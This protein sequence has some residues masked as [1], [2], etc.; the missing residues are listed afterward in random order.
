MKKKILMIIIFA[1]LMTLRE[2]NANEFAAY[3]PG[4]KNYLDNDNM[5]ISDNFM[6]TDDDMLVKANTEYTISFPGFD[7]I[8]EGITIEISGQ[9]TYLLG[10]VDELDSCEMDPSL[11]VCT[12]T[13]SAS[14]DYLYFEMYAPMLSLYYDYYELET[15]QLEEGLIS[16]DYEEYIAPFIDTTI[17]EFLGAGAYITSYQSNEAIEVIISDHIIAV[18]DIDGDISDQIIIVSDEYTGNEQIVGDY[19]VVLKVSDAANNNSLF[20]LTVMVKD[21]IS[22]IIT[23]PSTIT[24]EV[25]N[26]PTIQTII[27]DNFIINDEYDNNVEG[28]LINDD[29]TLN[30][31]E[32]GDYSVTYEVVDDSLNTASVGFTVS[33]VDTTPPEMIG[34]NIHNSYLSNPLSFTDILNR[35]SFTDNY[36]DLTNIDP[37]IMI[38]GYSSNEALPGTYYINIEILDSS[39]NILS[40]ILTVNVIDDI[41]PSIGGPINYSGSYDL[42]PTLSDFIDMLSVSDNIDDLTTDD[43]YIISDTYTTRTT[44]VGDYV[45]VFGVKDSNNNEYTHQIDITLFDGVAPVIYVDNYIITVNLSA[46]FNEDDALKLLLNSQELENG[47]YTITRLIDEYTGNEKIPGSYVYRL[48]F[49]NDKG[50]VFEKEFLVKV[51]N[52]N[53]LSVNKDLLVRNIAIYSSAVGYLIFMT[54]KRKKHKL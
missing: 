38:D 53:T 31:H 5:I 35:I 36:T 19:E 25:S 48:S 24:I 4:G 8:G 41:A 45:I 40:E 23:G 3:L 2:V 14:E 13:T 15:F 28:Y 7:L 54:V 46:T 9:E 44:E 47:N 29:Y 12:F 30:N 26:L 42:G 1:V 43:I 21:E 20:T 11:I 10:S 32:L 22:P 50:D 27:S 17:P 18:D 6:H 16:T 52:P 49:M 37:T 33:V 34:D 51:E 39:G